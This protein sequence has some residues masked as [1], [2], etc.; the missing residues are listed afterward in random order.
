MHLAVTALL[1]LA[2]SPVLAADAKVVKTLPFDYTVASVEDIDRDGSTYTIVTINL[3]N[4]PTSLQQAA[5]HCGAKNAGGYTWDIDGNVANVDPSDSRL[6]R[7]TG[8][9]DTS[10]DFKNAKT[11]R[12][13]V[14]SFTLGLIVD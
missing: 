12:C 10:G 7:L 11:L 6:F 14:T 4:G 8:I 2:A 1:F 3:K 5:F 9:G 13:R